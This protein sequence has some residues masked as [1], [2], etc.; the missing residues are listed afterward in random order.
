VDI[1]LTM[2]SVMGTI[3]SFTMG[4]YGCRILH[5][6]ETDEEGYRKKIVPRLKTH[7]KQLLRAHLDIR[8]EG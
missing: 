6:E 4:N 5:M 8:N 1:E 3:S 7:L 2:A